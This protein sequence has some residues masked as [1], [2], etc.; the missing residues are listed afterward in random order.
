MSCYRKRVKSIILTGAFVKAYGFSPVTMTTPTPVPLLDKQLATAAARFRA[1]TG[2]PFFTMQQLE[3]EDAIL[4]EKLRKNVQLQVPR[5]F[6][7]AVSVFFGQ[8]SVQFIITVLIL[9]ITCRMSLG[10]FHITD[11]IAFM[12]TGAGWYVMEWVIHDKIFHGK[13]SSALHPFE[14]HDRHHNLP[15]FHVA[16]DTLRMCM[17]WFMAV[18]TITAT[19]I[20]LGAP[21]DISLTVLFAY[22]WFGLTYEGLHFLTHTKVPLKGHLQQ[23]RKN[24]VIHHL[25][26][27]HNFGMGPTFVDEIAGT[28]ITRDSVL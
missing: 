27:Q 18:T 14:S 5:T 7:E 11:L 24:H 26:P 3:R 2:Q 1:K 12:I 15:F 8:Q 20:I 6:K 23:I 9:T 22:T 16:V 4:T 10:S 13:D 19:A 28:L 17:M 25:S 21:P